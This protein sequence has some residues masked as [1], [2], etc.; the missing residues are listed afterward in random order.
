MSKIKIVTDSTSDIPKRVREQLDIEVV[1][2]KVIF[3]EETFMDSV[4]IMSKS[5]L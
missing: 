2:L 5:I 4:T 1:P 3:G